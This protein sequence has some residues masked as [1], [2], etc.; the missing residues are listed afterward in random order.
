VQPSLLNPNLERYLWLP[1]ETSPDMSDED[2]QSE[3]ETMFAASRLTRQFVDGQIPPEDY[4][5]GLADIGYDPNE[6]EAM[7]EAGI[8]LGY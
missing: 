6:L 5:D 3:M 7:W 4:Y 1:A 2:W 8:S